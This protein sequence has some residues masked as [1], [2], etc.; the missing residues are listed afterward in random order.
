MENSFERNGLFGTDRL[1]C[2]FVFLWEWIVLIEPRSVLL[3]CHLLHWRILQTETRDHDNCFQ[4]EQS[5]PFRCSAR[6]FMT[7][8]E[9]TLVQHSYLYKHTE[10]TGTVLATEVAISVPGKAII[11]I[12]WEKQPMIHA[13]V[14]S[15]VHFFLHYGRNACIFWEACISAIVKK[16]MDTT[17]NVS[18]NHRLFFSPD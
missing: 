9:Q 2:G 16:E 18:M 3:C 13:H 17:G 11:L 7:W 4:D 1:G 6:E 15:C 14:S 12:R 5:W 8:P 10:N